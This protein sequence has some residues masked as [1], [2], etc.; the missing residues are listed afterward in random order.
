MELAS[1][2]PPK[3]VVPNRMKHPRGV[4]APTKIVVE[5]V[6]ETCSSDDCENNPNVQQLGKRRSRTRGNPF[7]LD[8]VEVDGGGGT[9]DEEEEEESEELSECEGQPSDWST[10]HSESDNGSRNE[11][12]EEDMEDIIMETLAMC[13]NCFRRAG[14][15]TDVGERHPMDLLTVPSDSINS[16]MYGKKFSSLSRGLVEITQHIGLCRECCT[17]LDCLPQGE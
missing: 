13:R 4:R 8:S 10:N 1:T 11:S 3:Q 9:D 5:T 15:G 14:L 17:Y 16:G 12:H 7:V 6:D 2:V